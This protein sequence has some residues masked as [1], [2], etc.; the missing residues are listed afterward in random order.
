MQTL[1]TVSEQFN[2]YRPAKKWYRSLSQRAAVCLILQDHPEQGL[3]LLM[4]ERASHKDDPWSGHMAFPGGKQ[5]P[6][7]TTI[8]CAAL[9]ELEEEIAVPSRAIQFVGRLSDIVA[10]PPAQG[11]KPMVVS[12]MVFQSH[13]PF[14]TQANHEVADVVWVPL[15]LFNKDNQQTMAWSK[16]GFTIDIPCYFYQSKRIWGLSL[17]MIEELMGVIVP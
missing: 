8:M 2:D 13:K 3:S 10:R 17:L 14:K 12:P 15:S 1:D 6:E 5:D 4:I 16:L 9:R 7:D 11:K